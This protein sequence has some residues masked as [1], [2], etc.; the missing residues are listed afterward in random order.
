VQ[1]FDKRQQLRHFCDMNPAL[2][3][4]GKAFKLELV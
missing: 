2:I 4:L 3:E 1:R